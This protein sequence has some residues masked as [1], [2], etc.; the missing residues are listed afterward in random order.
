LVIDLRPLNA[1]CREMGCSFE[2]LKRLRFLARPN[3]WA[4]SVDIADGFHCCAIA[5]EPRCFMTFMLQGK[6]Y[7]HA[8]LPFGWRGSPAVFVRIMRVLT[9]LLRN[10][11]GFPRAP[12]QGGA[13]PTDHDMRRRLDMTPADWMVFRDRLLQRE[14]IKYQG[15]RTLP[16]CDDYLLLF[17]SKE[18]ALQG[19]VVVRRVLDFLG[20]E[21]AG[22]D[23]CIW[24]PVQRLVHLGIEI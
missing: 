23:K 2:T 24:D 6:L 21:P 10:P 3:D 4:I 14:P 12:P 22:D 7:R 16:Y 17:S 20:L 19:A 11:D 8:V 15:A 18:A 9:R 13:A 5:P 1:Y